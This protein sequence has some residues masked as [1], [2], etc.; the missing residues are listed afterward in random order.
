MTP[1]TVT[2][3]VYG[4][5]VEFRYGESSEQA[6]ARLADAIGG[7]AIGNLV[8]VPLGAPGL[9]YAVRCDDHEISISQRM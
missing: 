8:K 4:T 6:A 1:E 7:L 5:L 2:L 3:D 9:Y